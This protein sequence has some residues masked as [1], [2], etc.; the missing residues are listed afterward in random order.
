MNTSKN[1]LFLD[2]DGTMIPTL[3]SA[4]Y[5]QLNRV[6]QDIRPED[7]YGE[8]FAPHCVASL[9]DMTRAQYF[10]IVITSRWK[11]DM[12]LGRLQQMWKA[13]GYPG[14]VLDVTPDLPGSRG[15][16][17]QAWLNQHPVDSY[18]ILDDMGPSMFL[19]EQRARLVMC[20]QTVGL[21]PAQ[22]EEVL[23]LF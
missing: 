17:I 4:F 7:G 1:I 3:F 5:K 6:N 8:F 18:V 19:P 13:R 23:A 20:D 21:T 9:A 2:F 10:D 15:E 16:E 14:N 22:A 12:R 11:L